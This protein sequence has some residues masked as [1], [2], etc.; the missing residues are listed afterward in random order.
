[1]AAFFA[2]HWLEIAAAAVGL[3]LGSLV[4]W[5]WGGASRAALTERLKAGDRRV[6]ETEAR[7][8]RAAAEAADHEREAQSYRVQ[9]GEASAR[10]EAET[11]AAA[12]KQQ[13]LDRA[14]QKLADTFKALS[15]DA[16]KAASE[17][18]LQLA[19]TTLGAHTEEARG[20]MEHRRAST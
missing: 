20:D 8:A 12:E 6:I 5:L 17:Q 7:L 10:L 16:L 18:F 3:I 13:L 15:S 11:R 14:E 19:K 2:A 4:T 1:M 9:L